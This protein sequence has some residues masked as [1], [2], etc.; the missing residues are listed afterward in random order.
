MKIRI[1][2]FTIVDSSMSSL[3]GS[4]VVFN[5]NGEGVQ[6][7]IETTSHYLPEDIMYEIR[8]G[9]FN[10]LSFELVKGEDNVAIEIPS[11]VSKDNP[12][13]ERFCKECKHAS[14]WIGI[15]VTGWKCDV[16]NRRD[17]VD[18]GLILESCRNMRSVRS[19]G[20]FEY[21]ACGPNGNLWEH[22]ETSPESSNITAI[23]LSE[24]DFCESSHTQS[25]ILI[26]DLSGI[27]FTNSMKNDNNIELVESIVGKISKPIS[28]TWKSKGA[29]LVLVLLSYNVFIRI[30]DKSNNL[31][32]PMEIIKLKCLSGTTG[33]SLD[34][35][36]KHANHMT[37]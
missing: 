34:L 35:V 33:I 20:Y 11:N 8:D 6:G 27:D 22:K 7:R 3:A 28:D 19:E 16:L 26:L 4:K 1:N 30:C 9:K 17:P 29:G 15:G 21:P 31:I 18:G 24:E 25:D 5:I 32:S 10:N 23:D 37:K 36:V 13:I 12:I 14:E 2:G